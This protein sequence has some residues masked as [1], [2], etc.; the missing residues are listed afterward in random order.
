MTRQLDDLI[1]LCLINLIEPIYK[2]FIVLVFLNFAF[3][4][5]QLKLT[6]AN[7]IFFF[8]RL[9]KSHSLNYSFLQE[10]FFPNYLLIPR[11]VYCKLKIYSFTGTTSELILLGNYPNLITNRL[12]IHYSWPS[13]RATFSMWFVSIEVQKVA[14]SAKTHGCRSFG[15]KIFLYVVWKRIF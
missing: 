13:W 9:M 4:F 10:I 15:T 11:K 5:K 7:M 1:F 14:K 3:I 6:C 8:I 2:I 12:P